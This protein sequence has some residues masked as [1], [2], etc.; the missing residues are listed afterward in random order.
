MQNSDSPV[1]FLCNCE[2]GNRREILLFGSIW[3]VDSGFLSENIGA[4]ERKLL[5][6]T[7]NGNSQNN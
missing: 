4:N 6:L 3:V 1:V 5:T 7:A 2:N